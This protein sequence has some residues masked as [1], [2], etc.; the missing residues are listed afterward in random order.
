MQKT[1]GKV[2]LRN[3]R[4]LS[5]TE[6]QSALDVCARIKHLVD[7]RESYIS[8]HGLDKAF[9]VADGLWSGKAFN[10]YLNTFREVSEGRYEVIN[11]LRL[12]TSF[13]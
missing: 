12:F 7:D 8:A 1:G 3:N 10:D 11:R 4:D 5:E 9:C 6:F 13:F 2:L